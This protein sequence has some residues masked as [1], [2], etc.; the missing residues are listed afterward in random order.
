[1]SRDELY[2]L[3]MSRVVSTTI[4]NAAAWTVNDVTGG[5]FP[6]HQVPALGANLLR[7]LMAMPE[8]GRAHLAALLMEGNREPMRVYGA[9]PV[10]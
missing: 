8:L 9:E 2:A 6:R 3:P 1:M 4:G 5:A 7:D 10:S